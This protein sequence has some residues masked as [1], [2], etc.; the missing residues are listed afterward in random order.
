MKIQGIKGQRTED[1]GTVKKARS[2]EKS[3]FFSLLEG[4]LHP[5]APTTS[6]QPADFSD[7]STVPAQLRLDGVFISENTIDLLESF[8]NCLGNTDISLEDLTPIIDALELGTTSLLDIKEQLSADDPL[9]QLIDQ[10]ATI[11]IVET[12]KFRRG[13]YS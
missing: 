6:V 9:A 1:K 12:E 5:T 7:N 8:E 11:S 13:D 10:V 3:T 4:Q 2:S